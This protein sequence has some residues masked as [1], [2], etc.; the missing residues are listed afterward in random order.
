VWPA[1]ETFSDSDNIDL[2]RITVR[3]T[4]VFV[5]AAVTRARSS[6]NA[7]LLVPPQIP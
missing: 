4:G 3:R 6:L 5:G 7:G 2:D 1:G